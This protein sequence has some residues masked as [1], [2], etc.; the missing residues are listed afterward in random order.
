M[1]GIVIGRDIMTLEFDAFEAWIRDQARGCMERSE[2]DEFCVGEMDFDSG[3]YTF[4][5]LTVQAQWVAWQAAS[6]MFRHALNESCKLQSHYAELLNMHDGGQRIGF[7]NGQAWMD[8]L[9]ECDSSR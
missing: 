6:K 5:D 1:H 4:Q 2:I 9:R 7:A 3:E 8:R